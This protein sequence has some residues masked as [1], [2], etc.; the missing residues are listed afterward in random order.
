MGGG[1]YVH[2]GVPQDKVLEVDQFAVEVEGG[3]G[4]HEVAPLDPTFRQGV[5]FQA[6]IEARQSFFRPLERGSDPFPGQ[7]PGQA[8]DRRSVG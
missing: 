2:V 6:F 5:S 4:F 7:L 8:V 1:A 3:T